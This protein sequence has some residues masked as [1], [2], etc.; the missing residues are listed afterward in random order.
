[1]ILK[2]EIL[3]V[4]QQLLAGGELRHIEAKKASG[5]VGDS[6]MQTVCAFANEP[7]IG[8]GYLLLGVSEPNDEHDNFWISGVSDTDNVLNQLQGNCRNQF[9]RMV[10]I[11][12]GVLTIEGK[13]LILVKVFELDAV[14]KPCGFISARNKKNFS[15][16]GV[17]RRGLNNDY[18]ASIEEL[19]DI[20]M[21]KTGQSY[22]NIVLP[23]VS[24][25]DIDPEAI[26]AYRKQRAKVQP[27]AVELDYNDVELLDS[28]HLLKNVNG[29]NKP[30]IAG[31]LLF[32]SVAALRRHL[33]MSR[34]DYTRST[35]TQWVEDADERFLYTKDFREPLVT[36]IP[37]VEAMIMDD[38]PNHFR[39]EDNALQ[40]SDESLLPQ[41]VVREAVVNMVMHRD[42]AVHQP[43]QINRYKDHL[44]MHNAGFSLKP[45]DTLDRAGS[46]TRNPLIAAVL[47]DLKWAETKGSGIRTMRSKLKQMG[48]TPPEFNSDYNNNHFTAS[49]LLHQLMDSR[50][51]HW[52]D[53]FGQELSDVEANALMLAKE[54]GSVD[55]RTLRDVTGLD[56][57]MASKL[58]AKL[59]RDNL[60][61]K[62]GSGRAT[63]YTLTDYAANIKPIPL[64]QT[65]GANAQ[66]SGANT[67][68]SGAN[69]QTSGV[70]TL[71]DDSLKHTAV[72]PK[73]A[74]KKQLYTAI[75]RLCQQSAL[76]IEDLA[77]SL[78]RNPDYLRKTYLN[79]MINEGLLSH[80]YDKTPNH[81]EQAYIITTLGR[82]WLIALDCNETDL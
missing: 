62:Q 51:L 4:Y 48:L 43:S 32:G 74:S 33:P 38:M 47:Y 70:K 37:R 22:E 72:V 68:T 71:A 39:L 80:V 41:R 30:N 14:S 54:T 42:Y 5:G 2:N 10:Q 49:F 40:R 36:M 8:H 55:N 60:L 21:A 19:Q 28:F 64:P 13:D 27:N 15:K 73:K 16:T 69:T 78:N 66:T 58:L 1:M 9:N 6:I 45:L 26:A 61:Q 57:L 63:S 25:S 23:D 34:V 81:P 56:T 17:W 53:A 31:L 59:C 29:E 20:I 12:A 82:Q 7:N 77:N 46:V 50:Q 65:S 67:Q 24:W 18:E 44:D 79:L 52:L 11:D 3:S 76:S 35:G 75:L